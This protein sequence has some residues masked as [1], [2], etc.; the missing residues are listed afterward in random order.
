M[1]EFEDH[2]DEHHEDDDDG[3]E[4][5]SL[6][7]G[8]PVLIE[9]RRLEDEPELQPDMAIV[10]SFVNGK[11]IARSIAPPEWEPEVEGDLFTKPRQIMYRGEELEDSTIRAQ[12]YAL[13]PPAE[14]PREP[15]QPEPDANAPSAIAL[16]GVVVRLPAD[17]K[18][19]TFEEECVSHFASVI[20]GNAE[21]VV[22]RILKSL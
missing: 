12:L 9:R 10:G 17:R 4:S 3:K 5:L 19:E 7:L 11:M 15:W 16:L 1:E 22:D 18:E 20:G 13:I 21:P 8:N 14:L 6:L 2:Y